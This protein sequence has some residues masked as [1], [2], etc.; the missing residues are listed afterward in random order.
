MFSSVSSIS[1]SLI[2]RVLGFCKRNSAECRTYLE[3]SFT[4]TSP[5]RLAWL[6]L[7]IRPHEL[8]KQIQRNNL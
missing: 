4:S 3:G 1:N 7:G 2:A 6:A 5:L 8:G